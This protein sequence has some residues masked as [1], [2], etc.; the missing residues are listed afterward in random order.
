MS[1]YE[2][3]DFGDGRKLESLSGYVIC[4]PSPPAVARPRLAEAH[5]EAADAVFDAS[6]RRW[7]FHRPW[8]EADLDRAD[9]RVLGERGSDE[10][11]WLDA[12]PFRM[13]LLPK[14]FGHLGCFPEQLPHWRWLGER[15]AELAAAGITAPRCLNL[16]AHTG[17]A[18]L[19]M[20]AGGAQVTHVDASKPSVTAAR[21]IAS[22]NGLGDAPI[23][24]LVED[25]ARYVAR[26]L[27]RG[28]RFQVIVM[29]PPSYGHGP[30]RGKAW[31]IERDLWPLIDGCLGLLDPANWAL[32]ISGH[33]RHPDEQE[34][35]QYVQRQLAA[36]G[37]PGAHRRGLSG[38]AAM[39]WQLGRSELKDHRRRSL[40]AGGF[41]RV[42]AI[43]F[44]PH[45]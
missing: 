43:S 45:A 39:R 12:G 15:L 36:K 5:W 25:A 9:L 40:D 10:G 23:R 41:L 20:A 2:L 31:R 6:H 26:Q 37:Q 38:S 14:P 3:I 1:G 24:Y 35:G 19:A 22:V 21:R 30:R 32:L 4:R 27:R 42:D 13:P 17:G 34:I 8:P 16:F 44:T 29:D 7:T 18:T 11:L 28:N 33:A